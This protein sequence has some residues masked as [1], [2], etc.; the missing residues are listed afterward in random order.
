[1]YTDSPNVFTKSWDND[2]T[3]LKLNRHNALL[4]QSELL[5]IIQLMSCNGMDTTIY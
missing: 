5:N 2:L 3:E 1:L 4:K